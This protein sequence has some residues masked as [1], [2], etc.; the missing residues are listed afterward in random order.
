MRIQTTSP[1]GAYPIN[2]ILLSCRQNDW[3]MVLSVNDPD[4]SIKPT[5]NVTTTLCSFQI[6]PESIIIQHRFGEQPA[7]PV[8]SDAALFE[9]LMSQWHEE[10]GATSSITQMAMCPSFQ[11]I[12]GIGEKA[13]P[14]I[15]RELDD[16]GEDPDHW[17]WALQAITRQNPVAVDH[18]GDMKEMAR[19]W[20]EWAYMAGYDW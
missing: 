4:I 5:S 8:I 20:L 14:L 2:R 17:F 11:R 6:W 13:I 18:Q 16:Q 19:D 7:V 10:R 1:Q 12:I 9:N 15:L 3:T